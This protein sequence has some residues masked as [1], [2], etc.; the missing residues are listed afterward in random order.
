MRYASNTSK[1]KHSMSSDED[2]IKG[3]FLIETKQ[4]SLSHRKCVTKIVVVTKT[5]SLKIKEREGNQELRLRKFRSQ[6][7]NLLLL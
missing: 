1:D 2:A 5:T 6:T 3:N 4:L 7:I